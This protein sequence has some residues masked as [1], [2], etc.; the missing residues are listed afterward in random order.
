MCSLIIEQTGLDIKELLD[1]MSRTKPD[2]KLI[3]FEEGGVKE[4][5]S[6]N[7]V[8]ITNETSSLELL[9]VI[10]NEGFESIKGT[11]IGNLSL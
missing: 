2:T 9:S 11:E 10:E 7:V 8:L 3:L 5:D 4:Y 1:L 6:S